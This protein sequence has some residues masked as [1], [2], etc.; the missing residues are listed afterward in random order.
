MSLRKSIASLWPSGGHPCPA[1]RGTYLPHGVSGILLACLLLVM[2]FRIAS[3]QSKAWVPASDDVVLQQVPATSDP[4]VR[5]F[6]ELRANY[7]KHPGD[8]DLA[9]QLAHAWIDY[10]RST[11]DTRFIGRAMALI[12]PWMQHSPPP[13]SVARLAATVQQNRHHFKEARQALRRIVQRDPGNSQAW[14]TLATVAMV[15]GDL[16]A[17]NR[18]CVKLASS[19]GNFMGTVCTASL[20]SLSGHN[21]QAMALL[22]LVADPGPKAPP[23]IQS[24]LHG[25]MADVAVRMGDAELAEEH[26]RQALQFTPGDNFLIADY[27][28]FLL[29][30]GRPAAAARLVRPYTRSDTSFLRL[31]MAEKMQGLPEAQADAGRMQQRFAAM[32]QRGSHVY[33]REQAGFVLQ[34]LDKPQQALRLAQQNWQVQRAPKDV[35]VYLQAALAA[36][37]PQ[38]ARPAMDFVQRTGLVDARIAPLM[39]RLRQ[40]PGQSASTGKTP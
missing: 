1:H 14:L 15:Q 30:E 32:E 7:R 23:E 34:V 4:R 9:V 27:A 37:D 38:A 19:G 8:L 12:D 21:E 35:L 25:L 11:G 22:K 3:A 10:G 39:Q 5:H 33:R 20:R 2:P 17:A 13:V 36:G 26:F 16:E 31:V 6:D 28:D 18:A 40:Q 24:W 29:E